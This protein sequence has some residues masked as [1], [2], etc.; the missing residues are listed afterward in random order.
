[1]RTNFQFAVSKVG[2]ISS[3]NNFFKNLENFTKN[4][5]SQKT[6]KFKMIC[7]NSEKKVSK[8]KGGVTLAHLML[9]KLINLL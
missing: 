4:I 9:A 1:M 6:L 2:K 5:K 3:I 8:I 7:T